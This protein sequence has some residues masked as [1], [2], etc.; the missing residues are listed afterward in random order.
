MT[1]TT[2]S[3]AQLL[4]VLRD[5]NVE[6]IFGADLRDF[7]ARMQELGRAYARRVRDRPRSALPQHLTLAD[8]VAES[9]RNPHRVKA[10]LQ[11]AA[12]SCTPDFL[13]MVWLVEL[14][15]EICK[16]HVN[17]DRDAGTLVIELEVRAREWEEAERFCSKELW[18]LAVLRLAS[19]AKADG[20]PVLGGFYPL[21]IPARGGT[22]V[23][24][25]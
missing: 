18:D 19:L 24:A 12:F 25:E 5:H 16:V 14:G 9:G 22:S 11:A 20:R 8:L 1:R 4:A 21:Y 15:A 13:A 3:D 6:N 17:F 7:R 10:L 23:D 2:V